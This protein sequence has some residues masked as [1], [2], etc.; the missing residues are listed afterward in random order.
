MPTNRT[1]RTRTRREGV[2]ENWEKEFLLYGRVLKEDGRKSCR[3]YLWPCLCHERWLAPKWAEHRKGLLSEWI[4]DHPGTR[5]WCWWELDSPR[6]PVVGDGDP[7][8]GKRPEPRQ[9]VGGTGGEPTHSGVT[10]GL[11][12]GWCEG[13]FN[14]SDPPVY[15]SQAVYLDR[16]GL[17]T[18]AERRALKKVPG[19][20]DPE[21]LPDDVC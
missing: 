21:V 20:F 7:Y 12:D 10:F 13:D 8:D 3:P 4:E 17:L 15:E 5:P 19:A 1:R 9:R 6:L 14:P 2:L 18:E 16:H 11:P